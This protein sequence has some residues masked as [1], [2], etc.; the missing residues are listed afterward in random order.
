MGVHNEGLGS[1]SAHLVLVEQS[2][3]KQ[4][5]PQPSTVQAMIEAQQAID[6]LGHQL[7]EVK[8][9]SQHTAVARWKAGEP[10]WRRVA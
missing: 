1:P 8:V 9:I 4:E 5:I 10:G 3:A 6:R 7:R 2:G